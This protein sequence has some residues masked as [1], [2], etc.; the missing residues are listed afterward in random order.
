MK[1][2]PEVLT[3][4]SLLIAAGADVNATYDETTALYWAG[5]NGHAALVEML[6]EGGADVNRTDYRGRGALWYAAQCGHLEV[7]ATLLMHGADT[8]QVSTTGGPLH[9]TCK[10]N[11]AEVIT[12]L[13]VHRPRESWVSCRN[14]SVSA[15]LTVALY[16]SRVLRR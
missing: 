2:T 7:L 5:C 3:V 4:A 1:A 6:I 10:E 12:L 11:K 9:V 14:V 13:D 16:M 15:M 8:T